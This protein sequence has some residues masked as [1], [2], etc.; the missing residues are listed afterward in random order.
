MG[1]M[2]VSIMS[3]VLILIYGQEFGK[4]KALK[5]LSALFAGLVQD[6]FVTYPVLVRKH[7]FPSI[8]HFGL[9]FFFI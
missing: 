1:C 5:W 7:L 6:I 8:Y 9:E 3:V 4:E 2:I